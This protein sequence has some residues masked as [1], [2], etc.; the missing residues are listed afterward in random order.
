MLH[1]FC[2]LCHHVSVVICEYAAA[3][4]SEVSEEVAVIGELRSVIH[5]VIT[6]TE[7][8]R[9]LLKRLRRSRIKRG[10]EAVCHTLQ[11]SGACSQMRGQKKEDNEARIWYNR[12]STQ[13][14]V[15][16]KGEHHVFQK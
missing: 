4:K 8:H 16:Q 10:I 13:N 12:I 15:N 9:H 6:G 1:H 3:L 7:E 11:L 14:L 2:Y 5:V